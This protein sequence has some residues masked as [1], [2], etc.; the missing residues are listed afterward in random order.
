MPCERK[1]S[2]HF[3]RTAGSLN[4]GKRA[5]PKNVPPRL[6]ISDTL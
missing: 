4:S 1:I 5:E 2:A 3:S 6:M